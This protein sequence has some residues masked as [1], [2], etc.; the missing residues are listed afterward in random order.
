MATRRS[1]K[2]GTAT[3]KPGTWSKGTLRVADYPDG[4]ITTPVNIVCGRHAG[5]TLWVQCAIHGTEIGG[6]IGLLRLLERIDLES[7]SG[8]IIG[9]MATNPGAF[10]GFVRN[11]PFDGENLNRCFPGDPGGPHSRQ[12]ADAL[13]SAALPVADAMMDLHSGGNEAVVP[14]YGIFHDAGG[15]ASQRSRQMA[16]SIG[17]DTVWASADAW[18]G[19]AMFVNFTRRGKPGILVECGGGGLVPEEHVENFAGAVEG[20]ARHLGILP[21]RPR[22]PRRRRVLGTCML[23]FNRCG[24]FFLPAVE[25]GSVVEKGATIGRVMDAHGQIVEEIPLPNTGPAYITAIG[26]PYLPVYSGSMVAECNDI[27]AGG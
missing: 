23:V 18:L 7:M 9:I 8:T 27:A 22:R 10:R 12:T 26:R 16:E 6:A 19:G 3:A 13:F 20:V 24:G 2:V 4:P 1:L 21:G 17:S 11:T 15:E 25:A 14:F 5:P